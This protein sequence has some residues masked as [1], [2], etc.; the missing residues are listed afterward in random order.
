MILTFTVDGNKYGFLEP[1]GDENSSPVI[2]RITDD[3][4][5][6]TNLF[7]ID[8]ADEY[9]RALLH[10]ISLALAKEDD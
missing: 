9:R 1:V 4:G 3:D 8:D 7:R 5:G 6:G 10:L 2:L